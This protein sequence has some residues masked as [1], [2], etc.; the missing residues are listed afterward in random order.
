MFSEEIQYNGAK[1]TVHRASVKAR[2]LA[3][4][5]YRHFDIQEGMP[6]EEFAP[7]EAFVRFMTQTTIEGDLGFPIPPV[8]G[9][10]VDILTA[11]ENFLGLNEAFYDVYAPAMRRVQKTVGDPET[12]PEGDKKKGSNEDSGIAGEGG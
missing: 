3:P 10:R 11:Y 4:M 2:I 7:I 6:E 1:L 5:L 9:D 12:A 8:S